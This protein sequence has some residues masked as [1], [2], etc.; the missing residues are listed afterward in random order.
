MIGLEPKIFRL[1]PM[2]PILLD[3]WLKP[4]AIDD[5][6]FKKTNQLPVASATGDKID[7]KLA[8]AQLVNS[9]GQMFF[10]IF[11]QTSACC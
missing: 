3:T 5:I 4:G 8:L 11:Q 10:F 1:K 9:L 7:S 6:G 2:P